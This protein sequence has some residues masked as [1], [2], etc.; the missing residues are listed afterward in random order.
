MIL[1][2]VALDGGRRVDVECTAR[3]T[4]TRREVFLITMVGAIGAALLMAMGIMFREQVQVLSVYWTDAFTPRTSLAD[5]T[6]R[7]SLPVR[8]DDGGLLLAHCRLAAV[9]AA[10]SRGCGSRGS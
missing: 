3:G 1:L 6:R 10:R 4:F 8:A 9:S 7:G 5:A 2:G